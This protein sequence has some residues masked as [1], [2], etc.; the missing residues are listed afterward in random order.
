MWPLRLSLLSLRAAQLSGL[1]AVDQRYGIISGIYLDEVSA[2]VSVH[3]VFPDVTFVLYDKS[4]SIMYDPPLTAAVS[5]Q[6]ARLSH[7]AS[8]VSAAHH[9][10]T[11]L[12]RCMTQYTGDQSP[13]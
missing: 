12:T 9:A 5:C 3:G 1:V 6:H 10:W 4:E 13:S 2:A 11:A 7:S 8:A